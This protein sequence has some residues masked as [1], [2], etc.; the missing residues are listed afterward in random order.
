[1]WWYDL[2]GRRLFCKTLPLVIKTLENIDSLAQTLL[3]TYCFYIKSV[4]YDEMGFAMSKPHLRAGLEADLKWLVGYI[5]DI[6]WP[7]KL[8]VYSLASPP[9]IW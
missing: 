5:W 4:G 9:L 1:M 7:L 8:F 6:D 2:S 3:L